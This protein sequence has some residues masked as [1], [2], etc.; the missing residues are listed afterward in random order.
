MPDKKAAFQDKVYLLNYRKPAVHSKNAF[1]RSSEQTLETLEMICQDDLVLH[2]KQEKTK[3]QWRRD[4]DRNIMLLR[5][6]GQHHIT[7]D[8]TKYCP[9]LSFLNSLNHVHPDI[10]PWALC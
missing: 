10:Q 3:T 4:N 2:L 7:F 6:S 8:V 1:L 9:I 5:S